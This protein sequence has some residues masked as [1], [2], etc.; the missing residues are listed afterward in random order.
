MPKDLYIEALRAVPIFAS[1]SKKELGLLL[2]EA[3]HLRFPPRY[4]VVREDSPGDEF[5]LVLEGEL[6]VQRGGRELAV[7]GQ[8]DFFGDLDVIDPAP[9]DAS[10][11][12]TT[13]AELLIVGRRRFWS[14]VDDVPAVSRKIMVGLARRL[15]ER[16]GADDRAA[17]TTH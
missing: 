5:W 3:D 9:R 4:R 15:R 1:L 8:G 7:L 6:S 14:L 12:T 11:V 17:R 16:D 2:R 13:A 10:V